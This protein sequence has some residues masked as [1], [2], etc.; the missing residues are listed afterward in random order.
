LLQ[1]WP[2]ATHLARTAPI[3][4]AVTELLGEGC[5]LVRALYFDKPPERSWALPWHRDM[6]IAVREHRT[7]GSHFTKPT[8]KGGVPHVEAPESVLRDMVTARV[9]LDDVTDENGPLLVIPGSH[10]EGKTGWR[11]ADESR[12]H[13]ILAAA[14]DV[15][16]MRPLLMHCSRK[17]KAGVQRRRRIVHL[18]FASPAPLPDGYEW[19]DFHS[20]SETK[21]ES[22]N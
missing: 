17:S 3:R 10:R 5:G 11:P 2:G 9:H 12:V 21:C 1:L 7:G 18:E 15:L 13:A 20:L 19:H 22:K 6:T 16:L 8:R 4:E 14:G